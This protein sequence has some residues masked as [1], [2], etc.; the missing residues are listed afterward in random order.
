M[1]HI[2]TCIWFG[3]VNRSPEACILNM[4][5]KIAGGVD[6]LLQDSGCQKHHHNILSNDKPA[7]L[8]SL[9]LHIS[10]ANMH[11]NCISLQDM[12]RKHP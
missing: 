6:L 12:N 10:T 5:L 1:H 9:K 2:I 7:Q 11:E 4:L 3:L 8:T